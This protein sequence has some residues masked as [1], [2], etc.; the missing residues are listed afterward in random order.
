MMMSQRLENF[1]EVVF[2]LEAIKVATVGEGWFVDN[3]FYAFAAK[4]FNNILN[5]G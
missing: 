5:D 2:G 1:C 3:D 4:I